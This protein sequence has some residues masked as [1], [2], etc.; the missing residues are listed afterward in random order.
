MADNDQQ[1]QG[2]NASEGNNPTAQ[3]QGSQQSA[4]QGGGDEPRVPK[5]RFDEVNKRMKD[6]EKALQ[7]FHQEREQQQED[8]ATKQGEYQELADKRQKTIEKLKAENAQMKGDWT[9]ERRMN[10]WNRAAQ[11]IIRPEAIADAFFF[12]SEDELNNADESDEA[13]FKQLAQNQVEV[14]TY[15]GVDGPRGAGSGGSDKL[16]LGHAG[17]P[18]GTRKQEG[19]ASAGRQPLFKR[20]G[21]RPSWK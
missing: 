9:R 11:G 8:R 13:T 12:L 19:A 1:D 21:R 16:V 14:R 4:S 15:L 6:A 7:D 2:Q 10:V 17:S 3:E 20:E 18:D 5:H